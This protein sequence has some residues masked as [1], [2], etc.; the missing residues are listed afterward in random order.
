MEKL[1]MLRQS[2]TH[3]S[4]RCTFTSLS[5]FVSTQCPYIEDT[6]LLHEVKYHCMAGSDLINK[7]ECSNSYAVLK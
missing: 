7:F 3:T 4:T 2:L 1:A 5:L 6:H